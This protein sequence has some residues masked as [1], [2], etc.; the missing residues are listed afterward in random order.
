L[1][2]GDKEMEVSKNLEIIMMAYNS[3]EMFEKTIEP[4]HLALPCA[5]KRIKLLV[6]RVIKEGFES[7]SNET[8]MFHMVK[9]KPKYARDYYEYLVKERR[10]YE[11]DK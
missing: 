9:N 11:R 6:T 4:E 1:E 3:L 8:N 5:H 10:L 2:L 7:L